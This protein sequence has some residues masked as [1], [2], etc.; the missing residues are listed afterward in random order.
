MVDLRA[1]VNIEDLHDA[2]VLVD[3]V[4]DAARWSRAAAAMPR[5]VLAHRGQV[6]AVLTALQGG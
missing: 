6:R 2:A 1:V 3:P 4:D 5:K